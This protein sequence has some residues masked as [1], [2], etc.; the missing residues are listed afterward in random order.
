MNILYYRFLILRELNLLLRKFSE[1]EMSMQNRY[2]DGSIRDR[3]QKEN[4]GLMLGIAAAAATALIGAA[5]LYHY[6]SGD[7]EDDD[8]P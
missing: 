7:A 2:N 6:V 8:T 1:D 5:L 4:K 3:N